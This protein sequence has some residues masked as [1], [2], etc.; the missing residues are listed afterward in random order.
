MV[1]IYEE[2][3]QLPET[4]SEQL[5]EI[6]YHENAEVRYTLRHHPQGLNLV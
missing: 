5:Q 1:A 2:I 3:T 6:L 4:S